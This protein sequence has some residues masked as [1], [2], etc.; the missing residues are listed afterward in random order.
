MKNPSNEELYVAL[1]CIGHL[2]RSLN[3]KKL[4]IATEVTSFLDNVWKLLGR[5]RTKLGLTKIDRRLEN[6]INDE[7]EAGFEPSLVN[8]LFYAVSNLV[9]YLQNGN[10]AA[11][12][13]VLDEAI[14]SKKYEAE[15]TYL[16]SLGGKAIAFDALDEAKIAADPRVQFEKISKR[17]IKNART[18]ILTGFTLSDK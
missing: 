16:E 2:Q 9:L 10:I 3:D 13:G 6:L 18:I 12:E 11:I 17:K 14:E 7:Q 4:R 15:K 8:R 1:K 5:T